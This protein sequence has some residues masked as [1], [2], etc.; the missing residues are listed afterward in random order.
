MKRISTETVQLEEQ[1]NTED[2]FFSNVYYIT[3]NSGMDVALQTANAYINI[4]LV[5]VIYTVAI[6]LPQPSLFT[7]QTKH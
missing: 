6:L 5:T 7:I 3:E 1:C 2:I 4:Y